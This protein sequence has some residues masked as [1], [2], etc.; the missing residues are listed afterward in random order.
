MRSAGSRP[1]HPQP[2]VSAPPTPNPTSKPSRQAR[3]PANARLHQFRCKDSSPILDTFSLTN[4]IEFSYPL[5]DALS[6][7]VGDDE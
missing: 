2:A 3:I 1:E 6:T 5:Q 4:P 7:T